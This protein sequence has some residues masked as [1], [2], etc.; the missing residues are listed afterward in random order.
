MK[1]VKFI[2][3]G[4]FLIA[5]LT[6]ASAQVHLSFNLEKGEK[7]EYL[8]DI[9]TT[10]QQS[11]GDQTSIGEMEIVFKYLIEVT[12]KTPQEITAQFTFTQIIYVVSNPRMKMGYHSKNQVENP[13]DIDK[14]LG[15]MI[16]KVIGQS[17]VAVIAPD[18]SIKSVTGMDAVYE[19]MVSEIEGDEQMAAQLSAQMRSMFTDRSRKNSLDMLLTIYPAKEV[20]VGDSWNFEIEIPTNNGSFAYNPKFTLKEISN[21]V[22]IVD[23]IVVIEANPDAESIFSAIQTGTILIDVKTGLPISGDITFDSKSSFKNQGMD[24]QI[25]SSEKWKTTGST[26]SANHIHNFT[27]HNDHFFDQSATQELL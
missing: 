3:T 17:F 27:G 7:Y 20:V 2:F 1:K 5:V 18:G 21:D 25:D 9:K 13:T 16:D 24:V 14:M 12:E 19:N 11:F 6:V 8:M 15:N 26:L 22:A 23:V 4:I 10:S